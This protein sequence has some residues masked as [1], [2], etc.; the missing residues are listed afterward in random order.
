MAAMESVNKIL[1]DRKYN[2]YLSLIKGL[3]NGVVLVYN[4]P[5]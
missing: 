2:V 4:W 1:T 5:C 3:R